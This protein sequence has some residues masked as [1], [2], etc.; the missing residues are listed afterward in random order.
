MNI[1]IFGKKKL[2]ST[3]TIDPLTREELS[4]LLLIFQEHFPKHYPFVLTL[5]R[6]G[7]RLGEA[8]GLKWSDIDFQGRFIHIQ[9]SYS[10]RRIETPKNGKSRRVDMSLQLTEILWR[11]KRE[12]EREMGDDIPEWVFISRKGTSINADNWRW[13]VFDKALEKAELRHIRVHD[14]RHTYAS[15]LLQAGESMIYVRDQLGHHSIKVTVDIYGHLVPGGN[16]SAVDRL[17][18]THE[19]APKRTLYAPKGKIDIKHIA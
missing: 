16:K 3:T 7:M 10:H 12:R 1:Q 17:D 6:T 14:L 8:C 2:E 15:L 18:D 4:L 13:R 11:L 9:R 19:S 5:A